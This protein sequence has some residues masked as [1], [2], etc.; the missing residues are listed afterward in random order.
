MA[1][2]ALIALFF[3]LIAMIGALSASAFVLGIKASQ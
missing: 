3:G 2:G 1:S